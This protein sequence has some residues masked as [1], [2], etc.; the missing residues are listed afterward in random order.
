MTAAIEN[1]LE[2]LTKAVNLATGLTHPSDKNLAKETFKILHENGEILLKQEI[3]AWA[4]FHKW[5]PNDADEI[6][7]LAQQ[8]GEG[9]KV[10]ISNGS[11]FAR[12]PYQGWNGGIV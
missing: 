4:S 3:E 2:A 5:K 1:A 9:K 7:S 6:G 10:H 12:D 11:C 8:I